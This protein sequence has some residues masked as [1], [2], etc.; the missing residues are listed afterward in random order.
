MSTE[1]RGTTESFNA[2]NSPMYG[3]LV[4]VT[5]PSITVRDDHVHR[6]G[7]QFA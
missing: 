7:V 5:V 1:K 3:I 6:I 4:A 2:I